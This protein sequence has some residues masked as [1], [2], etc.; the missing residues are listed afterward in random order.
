MLER[1]V[2]WTDEGLEPDGRD[3]VVQGIKDGQQC[4][5]QTVGHCPGGEVE[6]LKGTEKRRTRSLAV[7]LKDM[8]LDR[9]DVHRTCNTPRRKGARR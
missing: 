8:S 6:L 9:S 3:G 2:R 4:G 7:T 1:S 5:S